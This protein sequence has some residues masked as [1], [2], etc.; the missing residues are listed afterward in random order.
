M[1]SLFPKQITSIPDPMDTTQDIANPLDRMSEVTSP[2]LVAS[3]TEG[4]IHS[5]KVQK[6]V[7]SQYPTGKGPGSRAYNLG[8]SRRQGSPRSRDEH[9]AFLLALA[10]RAEIALRHLD[11]KITTNQ[12]TT[13]DLSEQVQG[14]GWEVQDLRQEV[15]EG[16][17]LDCEKALA[18]EAVIIA[19]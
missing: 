11:G 19:V 12:V 4:P 10:K 15:E 7:G 18:F 14:Q 8:S 9:A 17:E 3:S 13:E 6:P 2:A 16:R 5:D 1:S